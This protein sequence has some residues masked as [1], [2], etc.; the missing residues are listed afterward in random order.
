M[1]YHHESQDSRTNL[2]GTIVVF[3][4]LYHTNNYYTGLLNFITNYFEPALKT[5]QN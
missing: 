5:T 4:Q 3:T 2:M 1:L